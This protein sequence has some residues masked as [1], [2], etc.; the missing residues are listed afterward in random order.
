MTYIP[1]QPIYILGLLS[2]FVSSLKRCA[3]QRLFV[4]ST[5]TLILLPATAKAQ[6]PP[7]L[8]WELVNPFRFI[9]DQEAIDELKAAYEALPAL[10]D[11]TKSAAALERKLQDDEIA[12]VTARRAKA[13]QKFDCAHTQ[14][15][16][17]RRQCFEPYSGWFA[18]LAENDHAKTCW[19]S[20]KH[21][22]RKDCADYIYPK[23]HRVRVWIANPETL[24]DAAAAQWLIEPALTPQVCDAKYGKFCKEFDVPYHEKNPLEI[25]VTVQ[26]PADAAITTDA[27]IVVK[28]LLIVGLGDS[29]AAGEGNPDIPATFINEGHH[30]D[31][32]VLLV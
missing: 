21:E 22:I 6:T 28:D 5:L 32:L 2:H 27:P 30:K 9:H 24:G 13:R 26:F 3:W 15:A 23:T 4:L 14:S 17:E 31:P 25:K 19:D 7:T 1:A 12:A 16:E 20:A 10:P 29:Y 11:G 8:E 18:K